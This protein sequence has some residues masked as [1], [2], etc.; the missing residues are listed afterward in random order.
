MLGPDEL[1]CPICVE[2]IEDAF[3]TPCGHT[4]C[5]KC[6]S[7]HLKNRSNCPSC[8]AH[9]VQEHIHPNF[10]LSK[11]W[12]PAA[13]S[14]SRTVRPSRAPTNPCTC[15]PALQLIKHAAAASQRSIK[16]ALLQHVE[17]DLARGGSSLG[18][19]EL[20]AAITLLQER[21]QQVATHESSNKLQL[22]LL[23]LQHAK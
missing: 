13:C 10:L 12:C 17:A 8:G 6:I 22:L 3:V 9:L 23:F 21:R 7:T 2:T 11:V 15:L 14:A 16:A 4:F 1:A 20:D 18:L 19:Q 5:Y